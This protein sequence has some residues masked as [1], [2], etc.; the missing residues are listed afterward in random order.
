[1]CADAPAGFPIKACLGTAVPHHVSHLFFK[2]GCSSLAKLGG[3]EFMR[4]NAEEAELAASRL[5]V[6]GTASRRQ[7]ARLACGTCALQMCLPTLHTTGEQ[8][9]AMM[10]DAEERAAREVEAAEQAR[11]QRESSPPSSQLPSSESGELGTVAR[12]E[13][14]NQAQ[15]ATSG[16]VVRVGP[17]RAQV[18]DRALYAAERK[19]FMSSKPKPGVSREQARSAAGAKDAP[20]KAVEGS[21]SKADFMLMQREVF[22]LGG[23]GPP[24]HVRGAGPRQTMACSQTRDSPACVSR[25]G[26]AV[27]GAFSPPLF[28]LGP[29]RP[30]GVGMMGRRWGGPHAALGPCS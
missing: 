13:P 6:Y 17:P 12:A 24:A 30:A 7:T 20:A 1:M 29:V 14:G 2:C 27:R 28:P 18:Q 10:D 11:D 9:L 23:W 3:N 8:F 19:A 16:P 5:A 25:S 4:R 21:V 22:N 26:T 15:T